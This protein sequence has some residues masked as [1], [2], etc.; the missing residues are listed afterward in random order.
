LIVP[1]VSVFSSKTEYIRK[2]KKDIT[3]WTIVTCLYEVIYTT[4]FMT[5][6]CDTTMK[7]RCHLLSCTFTWKGTWGEIVARISMLLVGALEDDDVDGVM[8]LLLLADFSHQWQLLNFISFFIIQ[9]WS[10]L[11][12]NI[13]AAFWAQEAHQ[14][15]VFIYS[16]NMLYFHY[17][18]IFQ[19]LSPL[20]KIIFKVNSVLFILEYFFRIH[21]LKFMQVFS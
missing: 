17:L 20:L 5:L 6:Q 15:S 2:S 16:N 1:R 8:V 10:I 13:D 9:F 21:F 3:F 4:R 12:G 11:H 7:G 14:P 19:P 18:P